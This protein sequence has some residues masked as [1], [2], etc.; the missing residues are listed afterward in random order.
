MSYYD[1][2]GYAQDNS[3]QTDKDKKIDDGVHRDSKGRAT[4][5]NCGYRAV[6]EMDN[7][8]YYCPNCLETH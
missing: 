8:G 5:G 7:G 2:S 3:K 1:F 4:C 6:P